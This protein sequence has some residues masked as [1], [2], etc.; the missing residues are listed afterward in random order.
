MI[1]IAFSFEISKIL[2]VRL[3]AILFPSD[4][5]HC[6]KSNKNFANSFVTV[7]SNQSTDTWTFLALLM[8]Q[9]PNLMSILYCVYHF[10]KCLSQSETLCNIFNVLIFL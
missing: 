8:F 6:Y 5:L 4:L 7:F 9:V 2:S 10:I 3:N 1:L